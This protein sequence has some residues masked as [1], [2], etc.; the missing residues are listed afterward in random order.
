[1]NRTIFKTALIGM[2]GSLSRYTAFMAQHPSYEA[3]LWVLADSADDARAAATEWFRYRVMPH[4]ADDARTR[5]ARARYYMPQQ[6]P[7]ATRQKSFFDI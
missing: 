2:F 7:D 5:R 3:Q 6:T 1:M 4:L